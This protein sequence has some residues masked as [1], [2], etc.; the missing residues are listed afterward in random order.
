ME[1]LLHDAFRTIK[2]SCN[3]RLCEHCLKKS[4]KSNIPAFLKTPEVGFSFGI[5]ADRLD[6]RRGPNVQ[7][8]Y[9]S[10]WLSDGAP[11]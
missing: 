2:L 9:V 1:C 8:I 10:L 4:C 11:L 6:S 5:F 7:M 3:L